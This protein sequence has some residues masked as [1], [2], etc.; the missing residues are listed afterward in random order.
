[1][2]IMISLRTRIFLVITALVSITVIGGIVMIWY[3]QRIENVLN[4]I[5][6]KHLAAY[7]SAQSLEVALIKQKGFLTYYF[8]DGD[9]DWLRQLNEYRQLFTRRLQEA[10]QMD[11]NGNHGNILEEIERE[12]LSYIQG[13][14]QVIAYY[15][16]GE[17][18][19][20][21]ELH[22]Q[23]RKHF[24]S[25]ID[26]CEK[27]KEIHTRQIMEAKTHTLMQAS[28]LRM[29]AL[30]AMVGGMVLA[31]GLLAILVGQILQPVNRLFEATS[32]SIPPLPTDN[33]VDALS[34]RVHGLLE[35]VDQTHL[36]LERS[37]ESLLQ[38]EKMAMVGKLA[39]GM[40]HSIRN[41]F[42]S[43][44]MRLFSLSRSL[45]LDSEQKE[46]FQ[47]ISEEIRHIDTIVQNFLEFSRPPKLKMQRLSPSAVVDM[48]LQLLRHRLKSYDVTVHLE[49][50]QPLPDVSV[51]PEQLKEVLVN[52]IINACE[53]MG[54]GG[55][56]TIR[57]TV[58]TEAAGEAAVIQVS[59]NGPGI[60]EHLAVKVFQPF[61]TTKEEGTGLGLSI[62]GRIINEHGGRIRLDPKEGMGASFVITLPVIK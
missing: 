40:A 26:L 8:L 23:V 57:E 27:Y 59:D 6:D 7:Q 1:M 12:Y 20:G 4:E 24:F 49:R 39:A 18:A 60:P 48:A 50:G 9:L 32:G 55:R 52:L 22:K 3:T 19:K 44:Q 61:F 51:D 54:N 31:I 35:D 14:D 17:R 2:K 15:Q 29:T 53:A 46:D 62:V 30:V 11:G 38:A 47:V 13:K 37:R 10:S 43:V 34:Q 42:T 25:L 5:I 36:A 56:I 21:A 16:N 28:R 58:A 33:I 41:P 45:K